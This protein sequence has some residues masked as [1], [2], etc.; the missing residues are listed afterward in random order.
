MSKRL[1][2]KIFNRD[3]FACVYCG[4]RPPTILHIDHVIPVAN[5]GPT[6]EDNLVT[7]CAD[8]NM[9][10]ATT[11]VAAP[12]SKS[13]K[14]KRAEIAERSAQLKALLEYEEAKNR[15]DLDFCRDIAA[16]VSEAFGGCKVTEVGMRDIRRAYKFWGGD[17]VDLP[18]CADVSYTRFGTTDSS[19]WRYMWSVF[20]NRRR[21]RG[22]VYGK[23][24]AQ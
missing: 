15:Q 5:G 6:V 2:F 22:A 13:A 14:E 1:R 23:P 8:C 20:H 16:K 21:E 18:S 3:G 12:T 4:A 10:K 7:A 17:I 24:R 19:T 9:G 11:L